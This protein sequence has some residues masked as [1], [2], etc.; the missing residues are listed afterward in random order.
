MLRAQPEIE[1]MGE[2]STGQTELR[3]TQLGALEI[4]LPSEAQQRRL[5]PKLDALEAQADHALAES[6]ALAALR[7][8][9][10]PQLMSGRLRVKD[11]EKIVEDHT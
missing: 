8:T 7:D 2:G 6:V 9:L 3:R 4:T 1:A 10:L 5:R 11:A